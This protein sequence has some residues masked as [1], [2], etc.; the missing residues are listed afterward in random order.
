MEKKIKILTGIVI[1]LIIML[2]GFM[3]YFI[4]DK[5]NSIDKVDNNIEKDSNLGSYYEIYEEGDIVEV[6]DSKMQHVIPNYIKKIYM[7]KNGETYLEFYN[8]K[9][10]DFTYFD[11]GNESLDL[12]QKLTK[13][14][15]FSINGVEEKIHGYKFDSDIVFKDS[16]I[17]QYSNGGDY[18]HYLI[19]NTGELYYYCVACS[20]DDLGG[21]ELIKVPGITDVVKLEV[22]DMYSIPNDPESYS[23]WELFA[24]DSKGKETSVP[25]V[26]MNY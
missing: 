4:Y 26:R 11:L 12:V 8:E 21:I 7:L 5:I 16:Y 10:I 25:D 18:D 17:F 3:G 20:E 13:S 22:K 2:L 14:Y 19:S 6:Y 9:E 1:T 23:Y 24:I 15:T